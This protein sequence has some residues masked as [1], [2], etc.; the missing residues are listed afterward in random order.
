MNRVFIVS[1][2]SGMTAKQALTAAMTQFSKVDIEVELR[3]QVR[4]DEQVHDVI[5]EAVQMGGFILHTLVTDRLRQV[6][7]N[8]ARE[9]YN[10]VMSP[11]WR[12][13]PRRDHT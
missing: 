3:A 8:F 1:D 10:T 12:F 13:I 6:M 7:L 11:V 9:V 5:H 4:T 2:G